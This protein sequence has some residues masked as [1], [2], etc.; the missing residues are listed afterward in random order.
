MRKR[1]ALLAHVHNT[2]RQYNLP[3]IGKTIA[4]NATRA[5][6]AERCADP[7]VHKHIAVD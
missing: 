2:N 7:A 4:S 6:V 5:G 3:E 1:A